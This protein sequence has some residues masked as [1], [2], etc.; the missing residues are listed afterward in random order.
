VSQAFLEDLAEFVTGSEERLQHLRSEAWQKLLVQGLPQK[1][2]GDFQYVPVEKLY[3]GIY[4][5]AALA[6][7]PSKE[8]IASHLLPE[9]KDAYLVFVNGVF[10]SELSKL[11][12]KM[13]I[14]PLG[15][16]V[17]TYGTFLQARLNG[18]IQRESDPFA[19]LNLSLAG[20]GIFAYI[21]PKTKLATP[22]QCLHFLTQQG[23]LAAPRI[24]LF[25]GKES[26]A[27][28][29]ST[30]HLLAD[31]WI[32]SVVDL[33]LE[34][35][36]I[37]EQTSLLFEERSVP[38]F[39][40]LRVTQKARSQFRGFSLS[41]GGETHRQS[42]S[43]SL[44]GEDAEATLSGA[45]LL[46]REFSQHVHVLMDHQAPHTRSRQHFKGIVSERSQASFEGKIHVAQAAQKTEAYQLS[47]NLILGER[48]QA[49]CKPN[50]QIF[51]DDVKASHG[52]TVGQLDANA[53][54]YLK[55]RG[56]CEEE[57]QRLLVSAFCQEISA[58]IPLPSVQNKFKEHMTEFLRADQ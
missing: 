12:E 9:C 32:N 26:Q 42:Y 1:K 49:F 48:A 53:L 35:G 6:P 55:T 8:E 37:G 3:A 28:L 50:L 21:P 58:K 39:E 46:R 14:L 31:G 43:I 16:A 57:A 19:L 22:V 23:T 51:A 24:Q 47:N 45:W 7:V 29:F 18:T 41:T 36:A 34:E 4:K 56:I 27:A 15:K 2:Q 17:H 52:A 38:V 40:A 25:L 13:I 20:G 54:F 44:N 5:P 10:V 33:H 30:F 11:P